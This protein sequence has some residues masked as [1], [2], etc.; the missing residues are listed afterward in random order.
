MRVGSDGARPWAVVVGI[1]ADE[2][3]NGVTAAPKEKFY[4]P[5]GQWA[6]ITAGVRR[7]RARGE[8][9][10]Q[11]HLSHLSP[12]PADLGDVLSRYGRVL[13]PEANLGQLALLLRA[14]FLIDVQSYVQVN[15]LPFRAAA[16]ES[17]ILEEIHR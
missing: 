7:V 15:G 10:A 1:V 5:Y 12:F 8:R 13:V 4:A 17:R 9:V 3:H 2:R 6:A 14:E 16:M 11:G